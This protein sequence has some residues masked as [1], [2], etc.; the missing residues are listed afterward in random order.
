MFREK[1][2]RGETSFSFR[3]DRL[4]NGGLSI[5]R[6]KLFRPLVLT[7]LSASCAPRVTRVEAIATAYRYTQVTWMPEERHVRHGPDSNGII[8]RTPD[9]SLE[10]NGW[11]KPGVPAKSMPYQWGGFDTP[12]S[13]LQKIAAGEKAGDIADQ[14]KRDLG[15][16][17]T[18]SESCGIDCSGFVS[19]CWNLQRP[20]STREMHEI[21]DPLESWNELRPGDILLND[22]H[23]VLFVS[24]KVRGKELAAYEAGPFPVW[25][26]SAC[27]LYKKKLEN[28]GYTPWR[29]RGI[30]D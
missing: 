26:V 4:P 25:R 21:C 7:L 12:E 1:I 13:F 6:V 5:V 15:D 22:K 20:Y 11:W 27:G 10:K 2:K 8:V 29:Y 18:S 17:G 14:A 23:V 24:W 30:K 28:Q 3:R 16:A 9:H 19:R